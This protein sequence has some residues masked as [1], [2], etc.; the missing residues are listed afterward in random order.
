MTPEQRLRSLEEYAEQKKYVR[1]GEDGTLPRGPWAMQSLVFGGSMPAGSAY[2]TPLPPP[3]YETATGQPL[4]KEDTKKPG[5]VKKWLEERR[6]KKS[7]KHEKALNYAPN[8]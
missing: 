2:T 4:H 5:L 1:P 8:T 7:A 3:S 6:E